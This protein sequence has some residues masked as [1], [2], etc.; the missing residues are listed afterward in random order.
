LRVIDTGPGIPPELHDRLFTPF[1][2][3]N[4]AETGVDGTGLGLALS[5]KLVD[6]MGGSLWIDSDAGVG[7]SFCVELPA[8]EDPVAVLAQSECTPCDLS[9]QSAMDRRTVLY[10]EDNAMNLRLVQTILDR[11]PNIDLLAASQGVAGF[12]LAKQHEPDLVLLD[13][14]LPDASGH[15]ILRQLKSDPASNG[16]PVVVVSADAT[17]RQIA[18]ALES[19]AANY[20]TKPI[21]VRQFLQVLDDLLYAA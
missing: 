19:G 4:A 21:E 20:L 9:S 7:T 8:A 15:D 6:A 10:I 1:D 11:H 17:P 16:I 14:N 3:L 2:R 18:R 13:L 5:R 12:E